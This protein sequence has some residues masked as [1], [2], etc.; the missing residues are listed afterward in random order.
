M[1]G[2]PHTSEGTSRGEP[3]AR[4]AVIGAVCGL[5][6]I[7]VGWRIPLRA[8]GWPVI[9]VGV[10]FVLV[11]TAY[12]ASLAWKAAAGP[13]GTVLKRA[14]GH[15]RHDPLLGTLVRAPALHCWETTL[16]FGDHT[17]NVLIQGDEEP[18]PILLESARR[19]LADLEGLGRGLREHIVRQAHVEAAADPELA[20]ELAAQRLSSIRWSSADDPGRAEIGLDGPD[21]G[22]FWYCEYVDGEFGPLDFDN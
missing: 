8:I 4:Y 18:S 21:D 22:R 19:V 6:L 2:D 16:V 13:L 10:L 1:N 14:R 5:L 11:M 17:V 12:L 3:E 9:G 7:A 15:V 20:A